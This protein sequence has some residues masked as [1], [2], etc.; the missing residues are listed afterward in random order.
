MDQ[1]GIAVQ[2][3]TDELAERLG[4]KGMTGVLVSRVGPGSE[5]AREGITRGTLIMEV[6]RAKVTNTKEFDTAINKAAKEEKVLL[7]IRQERY[8]RLVVLKMPEK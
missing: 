6:N 3:L 5:A 7:R 8:T 2:D 4:Y 1:L